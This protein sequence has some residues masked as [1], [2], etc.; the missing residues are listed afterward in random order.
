MA[1][2]E[3]LA[4]QFLAALAMLQ[5]AVERCPPAAWDGRRDAPAIWRVAYHTLFY[6]HLYLQPSLDAFR[7]WSK[8]R[9]GAK[10]LRLSADAGTQ[11]VESAAPYTRE[12]LLDYLRCCREQVAVQ[13][14]AL[15]PDAPSG[16]PWLAFD[17]L[18]LQLYNLRHLQ[19]HVGELYERLGA[20]GDR[21]LPWI[22]DAPSR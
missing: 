12:E 10:Q 19:Q 7:R 20:A 9:E 21:A 8:H 16:F 6:T 17:R 22:S 2:Q 3:A 15:L 13:L 18:E 4:S 14:S 1:I 11:A 5:Q